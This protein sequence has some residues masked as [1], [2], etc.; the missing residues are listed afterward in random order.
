[1][2]TIKLRLKKKENRS[3]K[4]IIDKGA[5]DQVPDFLKEN[6]I[7]K[8]YAIITDKTVE[9]LFA[10]PFQKYLKKN[11]VK[12]EIFSFKA[13]EKAKLLCTV[14]S[15]AEQMIKKQFSKKD[16]IIAFGGGVVGDIAGFVA[17]IFMRGIPYIQIPTNLMAMV[18]S[19]IG[20]KTGVD[21]PKGGKNLIGIIK[22][23][24]A[25]FMDLKY[26]EKLPEKQIR[27][28]LGEIIKYGVIKSSGLFK[29]I[30]Q[31]LDKIFARDEK[32]LR[33]LVVQ[34]VKIKCKV[35]KDD[36]EEKCKRMILNYGHTYGHALEKLSNYTLLHGFAI[37]IG[38]VIAN[39]IA[40]RKGLLKKKDADRIKKLIK[41]AGLPTTTL[42]MPTKKDLTSD[43]K[44]CG[45]YINLILP[46]RIGKVVIHKEKC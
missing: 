7:G 15:L 39:K 45:D 25:V 9:K 37:S 33:K 14:E 28:G 11:G 18:D 8:K 19:S 10:K 13:G 35:V 20:G 6:N 5:V 26:L 2:P 4:I 17:S 3:Y 12:S 22:Q 42:K 30:E 34:S 24:K 36:E 43:K 32:T 38:M 46:K 31:N 21:L 41:D 23:P 44:F 16:A 27:N 29:F 40:M 1:M